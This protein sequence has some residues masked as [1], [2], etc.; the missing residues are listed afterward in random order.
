MNNDDDDA[1]KK[2]EEEEKKQKKKK[3]KKKVLT[4]LY[5]MLTLN[6]GI[7]AIVSC[8]ILSM[9]YNTHITL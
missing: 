6:S 8:G 4:M 3:K 7:A 2:K 9:L 1:E 5:N